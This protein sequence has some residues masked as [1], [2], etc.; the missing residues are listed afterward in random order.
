MY[1]INTSITVINIKMHAYI[2]KHYKYKY[3]KKYYYCLIPAKSLTPVIRK[4]CNISEISVL[5]T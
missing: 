4:E 3:K 1:I 2:L 5:N